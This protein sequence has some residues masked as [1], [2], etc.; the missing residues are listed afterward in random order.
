MFRSV[1][2]VPRTIK[3]YD[4]IDTDF[5]VQVSLPNNSNMMS[6]TGMII[7]EYTRRQLNVAANLVLYFQWSATNRNW[8]VAT[9]IKRA[10]QY[11]PLFTSQIKQDVEKYLLLL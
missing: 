4:L 9:Q 7:A 3:V 6:I 1:K 10:E 11:Q 2:Y 5:T 8:S